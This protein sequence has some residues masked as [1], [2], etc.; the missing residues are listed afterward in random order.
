MVTIAKVLQGSVIPF[1]EGTGGQRGGR[2][3]LLS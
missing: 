1:M 2:R 3:S